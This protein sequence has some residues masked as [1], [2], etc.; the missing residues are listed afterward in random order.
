TAFEAIDAA[1]RLGLKYV[2]LVRGQALSLEQHSAH[3]G[4]EL[5]A[6]QRE[7][8]LNKLKAHDVR[9]MSYGVIAFTNDESAA[10]KEFELAKQLGVETLTCDPDPDACD[11]LDK[12]CEQYK[13]RIAFHNGPKPSRYSSPDSVLDT[14]LHQPRRHQA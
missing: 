14:I 10:R 12:L 6:N 3:V 2:E 11:L 5:T 8:L 1:K 4:P 9:A 13:I 7:A